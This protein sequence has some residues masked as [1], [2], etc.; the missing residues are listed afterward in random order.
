MDSS[1]TYAHTINQNDM[2]VAQ[3]KMMEKAGSPMKNA[4]WDTAGDEAIT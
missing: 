4:S 1:S 2:S 3:P